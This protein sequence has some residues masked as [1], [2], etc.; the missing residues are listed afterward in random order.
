[1][2]G[3]YAVF[4]VFGK[5]TELLSL[6]TALSRGEESIVFKEKVSGFEIVNVIVQLYLRLTALGE[7]VIDHTEVLIG[8]FR[9]LDLFF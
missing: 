3:L 4:K 6:V 7:V 9:V 8:L 2:L 1:L 5:G